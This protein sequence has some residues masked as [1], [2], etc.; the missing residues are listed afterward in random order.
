M[1]K[2]DRCV[3]P[4]SPTA[5]APP[6]M[7]AQDGFGPTQFDLYA[8]W[9]DA[10]D[11]SSSTGAWQLALGPSPRL[12]GTVL[13]TIDMVCI[14][15]RDWKTALNW[16]QEKLGLALVYVDDD[17]EFA[18]VGL[19]DGG[20]VLHIVCDPER[21]VGGRNRCVPNISTV[22]FDATLHE[23]RQNGVEIRSIQNEEDDDY[24]LA[25]IADPEGNEL[26]IYVM[27]SG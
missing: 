18:V 20:P 27:A 24:R 4:L 12:G 3:A 8:H 17:H 7:T 14:Y 6:C 22:D 23:L 5:R 16:Y 1:G 25:T 21:P 2:F 13:K 19:P 9:V 11:G 10:I 15:V 26:N